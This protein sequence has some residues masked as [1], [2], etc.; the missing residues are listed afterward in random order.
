MDE[1]HADEL[2]AFVRIACIG[3]FI[4]AAGL[5]WMMAR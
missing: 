2:V 4:V 1:R 5:I 3:I